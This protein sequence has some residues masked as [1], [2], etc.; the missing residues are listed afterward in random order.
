MTQIKKTITLLRRSPYQA[1]AAILAM[2]LTF[3]IASIF[4]VLIIGGQIILNYIEQRPQVIAFFKDEVSEAQISAITEEVAATGLTRDVKYISKE[5]ALAIYRERNRDEPLLLESVTA[6]FLPASIDI[7]ATRAQDI[8]Q[9][10]EM[11]KNRQEVERVIT[12]ENLIEQLIKWTKTIRL[13]GIIFVATLLSISFLIIIMVIGMRIALRREEIT[14]MNLVGA[15]KWYISRPFFI[16]GII[17]GLIGAT[18]ATFL[19]YAILLFYSPNIAEFLG[20][21]QVFPISPAFFIY[22]WLGQAITASL[23][24]VAGAAIALYRYLKIR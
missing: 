3:F 5:D 22:L 12:P 24:G 9:I 13:G 20:P 19:I 17:Y 4:V 16:E 2:S 21:I 8:P 6:D 10:T 18:V 1:A 11:L 23:V 7:S 14:I 15:T